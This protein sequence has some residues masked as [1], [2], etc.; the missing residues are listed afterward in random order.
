MAVDALSP[1]G[2]DI[3]DTLPRGQTLLA[4]TV[5]ARFLQLCSLALR[6]RERDQHLAPLIIALGEAGIG[7]TI[8]ASYFERSQPIKPHTGRS[9]VVRVKNYPRASSVRLLLDYLAALDVPAERGRGAD[10]LT[11]AVR[12]TRSLDIDLVIVDE[13][14]YLTIES[15]EAFRKLRDRTGC[16]VI[17]VGLPP[18]VQIFVD[19][20]RQQFG[21]RAGIYAHLKT[22]SLHEVLHD[23]LPRLAIAGWSFDPR[24]P[25]QVALGTRMWARCRPSFRAL[26]I[27]LDLASVMAEEFGQSQIDGSLLDEVWDLMRGLPRAYQPAGGVEAS[28]GGAPIEE[29]SPDADA[30]PARKGTDKGRATR[31]P[32][33]GNSSDS[34]AGAEG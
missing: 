31:A 15:F 17:V 33:G 19:R 18:L 12:E 23:V 22:M 9:G 27:W 8:A 6:L 25:D 32:R 28:R 20:Q 34:Q 10:L 13:A 7:K 3:E 24:D 21:D 4:T 5:R 16:A 26:R 30:T 1:S 11:Q 29:A 2:L 14:D